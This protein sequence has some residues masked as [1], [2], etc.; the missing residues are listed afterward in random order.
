M[1]EQPN[2]PQVSISQPSSFER[3]ILAVSTVQDSKGKTLGTAAVVLALWLFRRGPENTYPGTAVAAQLTGI[4]RAAAWKAEQALEDAKIVAWAKTEDSVRRY[5]LLTPADPSSSQIESWLQ[6]V[7][8]SAAAVEERPGTAAL[9]RKLGPEE[10]TWFLANAARVR[11]YLRFGM[12]GFGK[13][14]EECTDLEST[15]M[16][17]LAFKPASPDY[18]FDNAWKDGNFMGFYWDGVCRWREGKGLPLSLPSWGRLGGEIRNLLKTQ[19]PMQTYGVIWMII[20][21]FDLIRFRVGRIGEGWMLDES[22]LSNHLV[23]QH[24]MTLVSF[25]R[26]ALQ[27]ELDRMSESQTRGG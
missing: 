8:P 16:D 12:P 6:W 19:T 22:T 15:A 23:R 3:M 10:M 11:Q 21:Y 9:Q 17:F 24:A 27:A 20:N 4:T 2:P 26:E 13:A 7:N 18:P 14:P 25:S 5:R 1:S